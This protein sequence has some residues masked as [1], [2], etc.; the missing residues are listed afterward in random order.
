M[1]KLSS[2]AKLFCRYYKEC[3]NHVKAYQKAYDCTYEVAKKQSY[4]LITNKDIKR[5]IDKLAIEEI[6]IQM[7]NA[8]SIF[9]KYIDIAFADITDFVYWEKDHK[10][11]LCIRVRDSSEVDGTLIKELVVK[12]DTVKIKL[13]DKMKALEWLTDRL[14]ML[15][16]EKKMKFELESYKLNLEC[17]KLNS[18]SNDEINDFLGAIK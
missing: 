2:N 3:L 7:I 4:K 10:D 18:S 8:D 11:N 12:K 13:H 9:Q 5:Q 6:G 17:C 16:T 1:S 15:T 14:D